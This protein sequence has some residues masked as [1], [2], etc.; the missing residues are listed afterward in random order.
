MIGRPPTRRATRARSATCFDAPRGGSA[1]PPRPAEAPATPITTDDGGATAELATTRRRFA[2]ARP[3]LLLTPLS[4]LVSCSACGSSSSTTSA[5]HSFLAPAAERD[6]AHS[7]AAGSPAGSTSSTSG[8]RSARRGWASASRPWPAS[9]SARSSRSSGSWSARV[10]PYL[11]ALQ[12]MP[13]IAIAPLIV[14]WFGY[15]PTSKVVIAAMIA[16][17]PMLVNVVV[18]LRRLRPEQD[19]PHALALRLAVADLPVREAAQRPALHVRRASTSPSCSACWA[20]SWASSWAPSA[21]SATSSCS[22]TSRSTSPGCSPSSWCSPTMGV[23]LHLAMQVIQKR[24]MFWAEPEE[25]TA[26]RDRRHPT[27]AP[28]HESC[29]VLARRPRALPSRPA[30]G[31]AGQAAQEGHLRDHHQGH[32]GGPRR[33]LVAAHGARA[34]GRTRG[35]T[36]RSP[37]SRARRRGCSSSAAATSTWSRSGPRRSSSGARR[38]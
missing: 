27:G 31:G 23:A 6:R 24:V 35:S 11:V 8:S 3:E 4:F 14:I 2:R 33:A 26:M 17:F 36:S 10:Y 29:F 5:C 30:A 34:T 13:K 25:I 15:G 32:L 12:S 28:D 16:F 37:A 38:A 9:S 22:S 7:L 20:R 21:G 18:G 19:R 1:E